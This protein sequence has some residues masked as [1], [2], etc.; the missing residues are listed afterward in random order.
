[1]LILCDVSECFIHWF[2]VAP[3][4]DS[5][6]HLINDALK[7]MSG[8]LIPSSV[9]ISSGS[10]NTTYIGSVLSSSC[11]S[12]EVDSINNVALSSSTNL[13]HDISH[14][15][16][17]KARAFAATLFPVSAV[18]NSCFSCQKTSTDATIYQSA[19]LIFGA[20]TVLS[21]Q[22]QY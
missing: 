8:C 4:M 22:L 10:L 14:L 19:T 9:I 13:H 11:G 6:Q 15:C 18:L 1:M 5:G 7:M 16:D 21:L 2:Q 20:G 17:L 3:P 12:A